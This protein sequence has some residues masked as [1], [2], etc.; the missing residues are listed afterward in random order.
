MQA[1]LEFKFGWFTKERVLFVIGLLVVV[2]AA[3]AFATAGSPGSGKVDK[4]TYRVN[5]EVLGAL[6]GAVE[7]SATS[8][9]NW[10]KDGAFFMLLDAPQL[11]LPAP[12]PPDFGLPIVQPPAYPQPASSGNR[13]TTK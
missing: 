3:Y 11:E 8:A 13:N 2:Y 7:A 9:L 1:L 10:R 6:P 12:E 4:V 5:D